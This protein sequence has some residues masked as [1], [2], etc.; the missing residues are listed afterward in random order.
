MTDKP[1]YNDGNWHGWNGAAE[2][3]V[4]PKTTVEAVWHDPR[5]NTAGFQPERTAYENEGPRLAWS[6]VVKFRV[7]KEHREPR[8]CW[9]YG[10]HIRDTEAEA[11]AFRQ[12][13]ADANPG[14]DY[15]KT[16]IIKWREVL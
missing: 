16:L 7:V 8:E 4:H 13:V 1:N 9:S 15:E 10:A 2:C 14:N 6:H 5:M 3:P 12:A 11:I